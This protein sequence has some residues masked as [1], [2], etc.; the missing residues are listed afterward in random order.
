MQREVARNLAD[1]L[2][3]TGVDHF[4]FDGFEGRVASGRGDYALGGLPLTT[5]ALR[6]A[7]N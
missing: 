1:F 3:E 7:T 6:C 4:D 2:N 5:C